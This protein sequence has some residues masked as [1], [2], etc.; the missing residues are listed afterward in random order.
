M[1]EE[2]SIVLPKSMPF[3]E[4]DEKDLEHDKESVKATHMCGSK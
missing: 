4:I 3:P 2:K 1:P